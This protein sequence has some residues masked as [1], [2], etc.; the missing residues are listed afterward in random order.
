[1]HDRVYVS[2][3]QRNDLSYDHYEDFSSSTTGL[4]RVVWPVTADDAFLQQEVG[5]ERRRNRSSSQQPPMDSLGV[6]R[7]MDWMGDRLRTRERSGEK[8]RRIEQEYEMEIQ[9]KTWNVRHMSSQ[10]RMS[11]YYI[12]RIYT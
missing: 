4:K 11:R 10:Y 5:G 6:D 9:K 3:F 2:I 8:E 1:M 7:P 12:R